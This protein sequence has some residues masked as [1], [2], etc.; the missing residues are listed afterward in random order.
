MQI[1]SVFVAPNCTQVSCKC[2]FKSTL[3]LGG[4]YGIAELTALE[5][6]ALQL[7]T[8]TYLGITWSEDENKMP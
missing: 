8:R 4:A 2:N 7:R 3:T 5:K 1:Q 6:A